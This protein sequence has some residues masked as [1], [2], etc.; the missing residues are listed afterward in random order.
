MFGYIFNLSTLFFGY[1]AKQIDTLE[2]LVSNAIQ[3]RNPDVTVKIFI[4]AERAVGGYTCLTITDNGLV[5][6]KK[7]HQNQLLQLIYQD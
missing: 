6:D 5:V 3:F 1:V 7:R 4:K 2:N